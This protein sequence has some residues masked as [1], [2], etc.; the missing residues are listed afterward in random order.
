[1]PYHFKLEKFEGPLDLLLELI[2]KEELKITEFS[3]AKVADQYLEYIKQND[4]I[5]L[6]N[7][8]DFLSV[9]SKLILIKS[10]TLLP[11]LKFT[12]EEE[13]EIQDLA[14][15]LE[16]YKRFKEASQ[17]LGKM[18]ELGRIAYSREGY[19]GVTSF[20]YPP[21]SLNIFD[22][23]K[24]F[25]SVLAEIP[26]IEKLEEEYVREVITLEQKINDLQNVLRKKAETYFSEVAG[27]AKD[28]IDVIIS[29][30]AMLEM[31]KQRIIEVEQGEIFKE[32]KMKTATH[33]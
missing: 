10:R 3:L 14:R 4:N 6:E 18:A 24:H 23:K 21:E 7:L 27:T 29:F 25:Q 8:S 33:K 32:I 19:A 16:E 1:M 26:I 20:F 12:D 30:L 28:K 15:Q 9:A 2:E 17:S 11:I 5:H 22:L 13:E 31:V